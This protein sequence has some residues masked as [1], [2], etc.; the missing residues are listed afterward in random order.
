MHACAPNRRLHPDNC[1][2]DAHVGD[3]VP[4][5]VLKSHVDLRSLDSL[6]MTANSKLQFM[7]SPACK[8]SLRIMLPKRTTRFIHRKTR[9]VLWDLPISSYAAFL[10]PTKEQGRRSRRRQ[11]GSAATTVAVYSRRTLIRYYLEL[12]QIGKQGQRQRTVCR[13]G[14]LRTSPKAQQDEDQPLCVLRGCF[15]CSHRLSI[16]RQRASSHHIRYDSTGQSNDLLVMM[17]RTSRPRSCT[18]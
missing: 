18:L 12:L 9:L 16:L 2:S 17:V 13:V 15:T 5:E 4:Q 1:D 11:Q 10:G 8:R 14:A 7:I 6:Q 3:T